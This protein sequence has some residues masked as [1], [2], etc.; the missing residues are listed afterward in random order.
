MSPARLLEHFGRISEAPDAVPRLR[1]FILDL[2]VR[3]K[4][5]DQD[6]S[7][8]PAAELLR[9]IRAEKAAHVKRR[10]ETVPPPIGDDQ[11]PFCIPRTWC[12]TRLSDIS[13]YVQ[14]GK[15]PQYAVGEGLPVVSQ[16]CVQWSGLDLAAARLITRESIAAYEDVRYLRDGDLLWNSTGT[17]TIGRIIRVADPP[18]RLVCDSHV[19]V[20]RCCGVNEE[21]VRS[22]L[23]SDHVYGLIEER[24]AGSTNQVELTSQMAN[25]QVVPLPPL[26]E[27]RRIV[28]KLDELM[29][30]C[31]KLEAVQTERETRRARLVAA[32]LNRLNEPAAT[33][34]VQPFRDHARFY[35]RHLPRLTTRPEHIGQL[36]ETILNLAVRGKLVPPNPHDEPPCV[37][38]Q[39]NSTCAGSDAGF[40]AEALA[41]MTVPAH[42]QV[43]P[44]ATVVSAI[45][46]CPHSTPK[47]TP[48]GKICVRT[49]QFRPGRLDLTDVRF[50]SESTYVERIQRLRPV[51][52]D[53]LYSREGGILGVACRVPAKTE[54]CLGQRMMLVRTGAALS[55]AFLEM[56]LNSPLITDIARR[57]TTGGAAPRVNVATVKAYPIPLP[58]L[59]EQRRIVAKVDELMALCDLLEAQLTTS[60]TESRR[61]LEAVLHQALTPTEEGRCRNILAMSMSTLSD[62]EASALSD[63]LPASASRV[64]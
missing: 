1:C 28:A 54:L 46:D 63:G 19:T 3:G 21:Y 41:S 44:L 39:F 2:A 33:D 59:A 13:S 10:M 6:P 16:K 48:S 49:N 56:T 17:G 24:A 45:V 40:F 7:D 51:A 27:Q 47:W 23:R 25:G 58:P 9:R 32:S 5:V 52:D 36:R 37:L 18:P 11:V 50:V 29:A 31:D 20:I 26:A 34:D 62:G 30:L 53:I 14:R 64:L 55:P 42:W 60:Q 4:L 22:W 38:R 35:F 12:W 57:K 15:S 43:Q 8:E 61:L